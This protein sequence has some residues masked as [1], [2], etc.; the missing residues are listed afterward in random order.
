MQ[1][2]TISILNTLVSRTFSKC[3]LNRRQLQNA[4]TCMS[5]WTEWKIR[6]GRS[7]SYSDF[8][9]DDDVRS[10]AKTQKHDQ[11]FSRTRLHISFQSFS[12]CLLC[13]WHFL[14]ENEQ[15]QNFSDG[16]YAFSYVSSSLSIRGF[17]W[18][19]KIGNQQRVTK[20]GFWI[21]SW[22]ANSNTSFLKL[23]LDGYT[24]RLKFEKASRSSFSSTLLKMSRASLIRPLSISG[25]NPKNDSRSWRIC[26]VLIVYFSNDGERYLQNNIVAV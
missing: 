9:S 21:S 8:R 13:L 18:Q 24:L 17:K 15:S 20:D 5:H 19:L 16:D 6:H 2:H 12:C 22:C 10:S 26:N 23:S 14:W 25:K 4:S 11:F 1:N 7:D 3:S